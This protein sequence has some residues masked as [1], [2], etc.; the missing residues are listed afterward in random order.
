MGRGLS[1]RTRNVIEVYHHH[2][3]AEILNAVFVRRNGNIEIAAEPWAQ[4]TTHRADRIL[5]REQGG[6]GL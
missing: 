2:L 6:W 4:H 5:L 1:A 3:L